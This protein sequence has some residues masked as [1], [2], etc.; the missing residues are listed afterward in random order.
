[1]PF[2]FHLLSHTPARLAR[3][4]ALSRAASLRPS[5]SRTRA[6]P[7]SPQTPG[8]GSTRNWRCRCPAACR[9]LEQKREFKRHNALTQNRSASSTI[10]HHC[11]TCT[12]VHVILSC[13]KISSYFSLQCIHLSVLSS[14][15]FV[16][17]SPH[18]PHAND[19]SPRQRHPDGQ[20]TVQWRWPWEWEQKHVFFFL[21][22]HLRLLKIFS[23]SFFAFFSF[24]MLRWRRR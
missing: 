7:E 5:A 19:A 23:I 11:Y 17:N 24:F 15:S 2:L 3:L 14:S 1:M 20:H 4:L 9:R 8:T 12:R 18:A 16:L 13:D 6:P 10:R 22:C 21:L